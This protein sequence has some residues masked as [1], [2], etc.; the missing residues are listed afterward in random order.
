[1]W[2]LFHSD[3]HTFPRWHPDTS[4]K[5]IKENGPNIFRYLLFMRQNQKTY[6]PLNPLIAGKIHRGGLSLGTIL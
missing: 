4:K 3:R 6:S 2:N 5:F 1:M